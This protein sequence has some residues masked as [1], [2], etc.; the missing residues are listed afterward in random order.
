MEA[1]YVLFRQKGFSRVTI[2]EIAASAKIT[3]RTFYS[4]FESKDFLLTKVLQ[5]QSAL[6]YDAF[7]T[8]GKNL[9]GAPDVIVEALF[10]D[11]E[12]WSSKPRWAGSGYTRLVAEL[13]DL[14]GHPARQIARDH[15][16]QL[17][18]HLADV[19]A[20]AGVKDPKACAREL[21]LLIEGAMVMMLI[22]GD[23]NY[24]KAAAEAGKKL[25][26]FQR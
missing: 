15:K 10:H 22:H 1:A 9:S 24:L 19:L 18:N 12:S 7:Q 11:L 5:A 14:P 4:H 21:W 20:E 23:K 26:A 8:F 16:A 25:I 6:A 2:D 13:A 17:E 3:K